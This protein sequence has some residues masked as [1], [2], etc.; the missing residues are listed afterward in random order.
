MSYSALNKP[1]LYYHTIR[2]LRAS[3]IF[4]RAGS[5][6]RKRIAPKRKYGCTYYSTT[7]PIEATQN[8]VRG[9]VHKGYVCGADGYRLLNQTIRTEGN[10]F[11]AGASQLWLYNLHYFDW[12]FEISDEVRYMDAITNWIERVPPLTKDA[13]HPYTTSLRICNWVWTSSKLWG[14]LSEPFQV[15]LTN[16][17]HNQARFVCDF[18]EFDVLGNH[19]IENCKAL[20]VA[21]TFLSNARW[22]SKGTVVLKRQLAEQI[23]PDGGHYERSPMY[24]CIVLEDLL[25]IHEAIAATKGESPEWLKEG[26][27]RMATF[28]AAIHRNETIPLLNDAAEGIAL[29]PALLL[30]RVSTALGIEIAPPPTEGNRLLADSGLFTANEGRW[31]LTFDCGTICPDFLPAHAHNDTLT[32]LLWHGG[33]RVVTDSG[34]YEYATGQ[35]RDYFRSSA[36]HNVVTI[37]GEEPNEIWGSFRVGRRGKPFDLRRDEATGEVSCSHNSYARM[38]VTVS[39]CVKLHKGGLNVVDRLA[40]TGAA[41]TFVSPIHFA[42][43][44]SVKH[45]DRSQEGTSVAIQSS[46]TVYLLHVNSA[47]CDVRESTSWYSREFGLKEKRLCMLISGTAPRGTTEVG[48]SITHQRSSTSSGF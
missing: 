3:Q 6:I 48:F 8:A 37:D 15:K 22:L 29:P 45:V 36:A 4:G 44:L 23:L 28:L 35:W 18:M 17:L 34:V 33:N 27:I 46:D 40:N 26:I 11:P 10:W 19:L 25:A 21:G 42:P 1:L 7:P 41:R 32:F 38:G 14:T 2:H 24:H 12:L 13:W 20:I 16:S 31:G 39:R 9:D 43:G 5:L 47:D 30:E